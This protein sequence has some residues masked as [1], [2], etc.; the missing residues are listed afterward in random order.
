MKNILLLLANGFEIY[1]AS[2]FVDVLGWN[3]EYGTGDTKLHTCGRSRQ[4][5]ST[6][7]MKV[8]VDHLL[9]EI[10]VDDFDALA[11]PGGFETHGFY[12]DAFS[13]EFQAVIRAFDKSLK[14]IASI[15]VGALALG[16]SGI[17]QDRKATTYNL[18][19][20]KRLDQ[21][22]AFGAQITDLPVVV[23]RNIITSWS[24][25]TAGDVAFELLAGLTSRDNSDHIKTLMG[26]SR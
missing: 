7:G 18:M 9:Q 17:L 16:K 3:M 25:V 21:L 14:P 13:D 11:I 22:G 20:G 23:D 2:V 4:L 1:E 8:E 12:E 6:F 24:P 26:F 19:G 15:C 10:D 5:T